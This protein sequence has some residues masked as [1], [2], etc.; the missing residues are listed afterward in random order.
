MRFSHR[1]PL[2]ACVLAA[3]LGSHLCGCSLVRPADV[4][5]VR[6]GES[7]STDEPSMRVDRESIP[8]YAAVAS[9]DLFGPRPETVKPLTASQCASLAAAHAPRAAVLESETSGL[10]QE[11]VARR[12]RGTSRLLPEIVADR[13]A[14]ERNDAA[15]Q[16]LIAY[17]QLTRVDLQTEVLHKSYAELQRVEESVG[18]LRETGIPVDLDS[19]QLSL[20][21]S[22]LDSSSVQLRFAEARLNAQLLALIGHDPLPAC[23]IQPTGVLE[24]RPFE[25]QLEDAQEMARGHDFQWRSIQRLLQGGDTDELRTARSLLQIAGPLL[26]QEPGPLGPWAK[27][28]RILGHNADGLRELEWRK[29][30]LIQLRDARR[31][32][33]DLEVANAVSEIQERFL[34]LGIANDVLHSL[35]RQLVVLESRREAQKSQ[36]ADLAQTRAELLEAE[37]ELVNRLIELEIG[38]VKLA[39]RLGILAH[40]CR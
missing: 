31:Q 12:C 30:Q 18:K 37:S 23:R 40:D 4:L 6:P 28:K 15:E 19:S 35:R 14:Q 1:L 32:Q 11:A 17:F 8:S 13:I 36:Y 3:L 27:F 29:R 20:R 5:P 24:P 7:L 10:R 9:A 25:D 26:G 39:A 2:S 33:L 34:E 21:R 38:H 22:R 16:A